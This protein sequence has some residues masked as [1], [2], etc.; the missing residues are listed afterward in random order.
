MNFKYL[1][2]NVMKD[3]LCLEELPFDWKGIGLEFNFTSD[4]G[5]KNVRRKNV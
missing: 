5:C 2:R 1:A 3:G 4:S